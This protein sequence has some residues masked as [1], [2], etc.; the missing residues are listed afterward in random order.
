MS[1][2]VVRLPTAAAR[3]VQQPW[4]RARFA[5][6]EQLS[7]F[8]RDHYRTPAERRALERAAIIKQIEPS[9]ALA[10][11]TALFRQ[12]DDLAQ[13]EVL[14]RCGISAATSGKP[15][16]AQAVEWLDAHRR[17]R[18]CGDT[19]MLLWALDKVEQEEGE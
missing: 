16:V 1:A 9:A 18:K 11:A 8:P 5:A 2:V 14:G 6:R 17:G 7:Q 12:L 10:I 3:K 4:N 15:C 13:L 19:T